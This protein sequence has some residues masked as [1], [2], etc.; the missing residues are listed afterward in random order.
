MVDLDHYEENLDSLGEFQTKFENS[1]KTGTAQPDAMRWD[2]AMRD[3]ERVRAGNVAVEF[4]R[5]Q[6]M[7]DFQRKLARD[8]C[9]W[10]DLTNPVRIVDLDSGYRYAMGLPD[11]GVAF[12]DLPDPH[13]FSVTFRMSV[14]TGGRLS[15]ILFVIFAIED[16]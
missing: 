2:G 16:D 8:S 9:V 14:G 10:V 15:G 6:D 4:R 13:Y 12:L 3:V 1:L 11:G 7:N 5:V